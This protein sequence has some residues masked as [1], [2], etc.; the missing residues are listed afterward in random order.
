MSEDEIKALVKEYIA[1]NLHINIDINRFG[2]YDSG[3]SITVSLYL[4]EECIAD[5]FDTLPEIK[6]KY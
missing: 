4:G 2:S 1:E 5:S 3:P 6:V